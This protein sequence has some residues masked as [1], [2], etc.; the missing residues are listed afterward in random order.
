MAS[1]AAAAVVEASTV[2]EAAEAASIAAA[3]EAAASTVAAA[4]VVVSIAAA[5]AAAAEIAD[6]G[7]TMVTEDHL[8]ATATTA[9]LITET[10]TAMVT[11]IITVIPIAII[12]EITTRGTRTRIDFGSNPKFL[13]ATSQYFARQAMGVNRLP[14]LF[15][16]YIMNSFETSGLKPEILAALKDLGFVTPT[17][18]QQQTLQLLI[19]SRKDLIAL[20]QTGTGKTAAFFCHC[21]KNLTGREV[22]VRVLIL[23]PT[24]ELCL[25]I[26]NDIKAY[27]K[28][29][30]G[31]R[32]VAV[33]GGANITTKSAPSKK[34]LKLW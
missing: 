19:H 3:V 28:Y 4:E 30:P 8:M 16:S 23:A 9:D 1:I 6:Q 12:T 24:R 5:V 29:L 20:A 31:I 14:M 11:E 2:A 32:S 15:I 13:I 7:P 33:Y 25:Q 34:G 27:T 10:S 18:I 22:E 26:A 21:C 17:P